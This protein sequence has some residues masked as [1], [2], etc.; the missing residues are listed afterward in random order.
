MEYMMILVG[1]CGVINIMMGL[2]AKTKNFLSS[3]VF[4]VFPFLSGCILTLTCLKY[5]NVI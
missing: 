2:S 4:K 1:I 3:L 5:F